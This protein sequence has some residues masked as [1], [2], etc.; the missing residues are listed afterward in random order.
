MEYYSNMS[1]GIYCICFVYYLHS[2]ADLDQREISMN[3]QFNV[4]TGIVCICLVSYLHSLYSS[5]ALH[6]GLY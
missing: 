6:I 4:P 5:S 2:L 3:H 1:K